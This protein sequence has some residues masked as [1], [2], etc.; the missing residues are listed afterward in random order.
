RNKRCSMWAIF[1]F[2][3]LVVAS[4][5]YFFV[6]QKQRQKIDLLAK[7]RDKIFGEETRVFDFLHG[8]GEAFQADIRTGDLHRLIVEGAVRIL[9]AQGGAL[10]LADRQDNVLL[11]SFISSQCP[12]LIEI[13]AHILRQAEDAPAALQSYLRLHAIELAEGVLGAVW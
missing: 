4:F 3:L 2:G 12:P 8:L 11:P 10:Y 9:E 6:Y 13:P 5:A 7:A 1:F